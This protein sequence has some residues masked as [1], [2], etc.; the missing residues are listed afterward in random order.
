MFRIYVE[1]KNGFESEAKRIYSEITG[2]LGISDVTGV[3]YLNRYDIENTSDEV[4][5]LA[6]ERIFSEPQSDTVLYP[7]LTLKEDETAII[8]EYLPGQYDQRADSAEQCLT[9]LREAVKNSVKVGTKPPRVRCAK[10][11][12]LIGRV[13]ADDVEKVQHYLINPVDSRLTDGTL[14]QTLELKTD[15]PGD[16]PVVDGFI[17]WGKGKLEAYREKMGLAMDYADIKFLQGYFK[18]IKRDPT[19]TEIRVLD[20][21]WSDHCRHTTF[22]T[23]LKNI[24]IE[25][26]P[27]A[28]LFKE[29]LDEYKA[30]HTDIYANR[31]DKPLTLMDMA[32]IGGK[33]L[34]KHGKLDDL[35]VS[36]ENN[37]CSIFIDVHY[38][39]DKD[40]NALPEG[41][42]E[43][44][45]WLLQFKNETHNHPTEIEP[46]GGAATCIGGAI[47]DPLS[48]RS[49]V[50]QSMRITGA[51]D[52]TV[53][54]SATMHGK[55]PQIKLCREAAQGFS[56]YGNQ[57]GL[58]T[59]QVVECYHP[60]FVA[61]R[62]EL[63][64]VIAAS[65]YD[66]VMRETPEAGDII[67]LLGGGTGRDG[68][69]GATGSSK[70]HTEKSV[71]TAAAEV[72]KGNAVEERKIQRLF[73]NP[74]VS[75]MIRRSNDFGAGGVSVAVGE[76]APGLDINL[77][78]VPKKY[79]GLNGTE[80][81]I[82]ESQER[83]AVVVRKD[84]VDAFIAEC[85]KENLN[86]VVVATVTDTN[87]LVMK[88]RGKVIVDIDRAFLDAAGAKHEAVARIESP[89][90]QPESPLVKPL[91]SVAEKLG[92][93]ASA[94][95][96][97]ASE[98]PTE[99]QIHDAFVANISDL[100][101]CSQRGLEER[102][103][104]SIGASTVL[105]PFGGKY[106]GTPEA[107]MVAKVPVLY[108][109][110][111]NTVSMMSYGYDPRVAEWSPWHGAQTAVLSSLAKITCVGGKATTSRFSFQ[112]F[113]G[114]TSND[115][116]W[117]YPAS[118]LLG[119]VDA[120]N[121]M[122]CA[123]IGG[124]DSMSGTFENLNVPHTLVSFAVTHDT[125][126][127]VN[128]G[129]FKKGG[130]HLYL[131]M[132]P[133]TDMLAPDFGTFKK[134]SDA[135]Y[136]L[137]KTGI[138]KAMYPVGAGGIAEA[139]TKMAFGSK[140]GCQL[141][142]IPSSATAL[143]FHRN[144]NNTIADLFTPLYGSI[145]VETEDPQFDNNPAFVNTTVV[146]IGNTQ[147]APVISVAMSGLN[148]LPVTDIPLDELEQA[149]E[150]KL[151][152]VF[153]PVSGAKEQEPF[154]D[155]AKE[156]HSSVAEARKTFTVADASKARPRVIIPVFPGTNCEY[157]M[158][159]AFTLN[160]ADAKIFVFRNNTPKALEESL[161]GLQ[162]EINEAQILAFAGGFSAGDEPDGSG[163]FI[164]N[165]IREQRVADAVTALLEDRKGLILGICNGF[166]ALIKT[167]LV[168]YGKI[169]PPS[170]EMPTLSY[171]TI[172]RHISRVVRTRLVSATSPWALDA[173]VLDA[174]P[175]YIPVSH[176]E[177]RILISDA[178]AKELFERGQV[179]TQY[180]DEH[181]VP[182]ISEP[183][184]PNG[185]A[186]AIEG[187][188]SPNGHVLG[189]MGHNERTMGNGK[190][191]SSID[192]IKNIAFDPATNPDGN[193]CQNIFAA[194]VRYFN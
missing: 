19:E 47:R 80:L 115:K 117:G 79:E 36:E 114:R 97:S 96:E 143:G 93:C 63:G 88:W 155:F 58:T 185:S 60:G 139:V 121:A 107:A 135:L 87:K 27:Y 167:G 34:R 144:V 183:D 125:A 44:E 72:Q 128:S 8:W 68:I 171:N 20:T 56:S 178:L 173:S 6:A 177:G 50:Y 7:P 120:Q 38:T 9:L 45:R 150:S 41:K 31:K 4:A 137:N 168:P 90:P 158:A 179:F 2:F 160:G 172:H 140:I 190:G 86:A 156:E 70:A 108:P 132:T 81:A 162:N 163:K 22:N 94:T 123:S 122:G 154:P 26:G 14:P 164:A 176:G 145:I 16:I 15:E 136:E 48:G 32:T 103:D 109:R 100:A 82:S 181:G 42:E 146:R 62:M 5:K 51:A 67:I 186:F 83:M 57:I 169:L 119:S 39:T 194:G 29:S 84:D 180:C 17:G 184:N 92:S 11:V 37:A 24:K 74:T 113:F 161:I 95:G 165:V 35:E 149:W 53:P 71:T 98:K 52:P 77:D 43:T 99:Q 25:K 133:Y 66:T 73:R 1:R 127:N 105:F 170:A 166:Q 175:H 192:L 152:K 3:R 193:S 134:N 28:K 54:M 104:G 76:L 126:K 23:I 12:I 46:F 188:T 174:R 101:C 147:A 187:L 30:M 33:Y 65:P 142:A 189:K 110:E 118:A 59:G 131:V 153:P 69:G 116:A 75:K 124:K 129:S 40:G 89:A 111:T 64:A 138:I 191:G 55:L 159:R 157:D 49:W 112:E 102:F 78:A 18:G 106:Q 141:T 91:A 151:A 182:A 148:P 10:V 61:K 130:D 13:T 21:Y 85:S